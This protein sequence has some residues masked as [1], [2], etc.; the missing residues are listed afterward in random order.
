M[1]SVL[2]F[3]SVSRWVFSSKLLTLRAFGAFGVLLG[4]GGFLSVRLVGNELNKS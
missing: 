2:I 3:G 4:K 1:S